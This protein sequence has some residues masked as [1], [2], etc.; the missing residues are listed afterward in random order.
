M[1]LFLDQ[2]SVAFICIRSIEANQC[3]LEKHYPKKTNKKTMT[4]NRTNFIA[5]HN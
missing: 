2:T 4:V 1:C 5:S 3:V